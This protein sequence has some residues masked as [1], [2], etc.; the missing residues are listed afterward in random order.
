M[1]PP[2][3]S[4]ENGIE[5]RLTGPGA[6]QYDGQP[7]RLFTD[8]TTTAPPLAGGILNRQAIGKARG[9]FLIQKVP[10]I[11]FPNLPSPGDGAPEKQLG[12]HHR[13]QSGRA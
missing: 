11:L 1:K 2:L 13:L 12:L 8:D 7:L 9:H 6:G 4:G 5:L 10:P 3:I